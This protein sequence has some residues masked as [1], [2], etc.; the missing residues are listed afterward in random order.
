MRI[1][2]MRLILS[3]RRTMISRI[4]DSTYIRS[5]RRAPKMKRRRAARLYNIGATP[6]SSNMKSL[7]IGLQHLIR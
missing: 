2:L 1:S 4:S 7:I 6:N 3:I 5:L